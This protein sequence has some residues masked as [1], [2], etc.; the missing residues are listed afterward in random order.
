MDFDIYRLFQKIQQLYKFRKDCPLFCLKLN[1]L[2]II[3]DNCMT[4]PVF[5]ESPINTHVA[6][7]IPGSSVTMCKT[8]SLCLLL[9]ELHPSRYIL[10]YILFYYK[11]LFL[12][13]FLIL[14]L[15]HCIVWGELCV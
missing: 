1:E 14:Q 15:G 7:N 5:T 9:V 6:V 13:L 2:F 4:L 11:L 10:K 8:I 12:Y 3:W